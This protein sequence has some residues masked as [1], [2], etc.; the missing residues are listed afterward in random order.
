MR[1]SGELSTPLAGIDD[2]MASLLHLSGAAFFAWRA[3]HLSRRAGP[4][5]RRAAALYVFSATAVAALL[6][7]GT[8]HAIPADHAW[9]PLLQRVDHSAIFLLIAGTLTA[10]HAIGFHGRGRWWMVGLVWA[11]T[12]AVLFGKIAW[13]SRVGDG[14]G[15]GL[16]IGLSIVGLSSILFL[17]RKLDWRMYDL[18]AAGAV[19]YVAGALFD[20]F[21]LFWIVPRVFG[22]HETFH[23]AVLVALFLHWRFFHAWAEPGLAPRPRRAK[24]ELLRQSPGPN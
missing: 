4:A 15:L 11:I 6:L 14:V 19:T 13:W 16:Y 23:V 5:R 12:W 8:Y 3:T 18:M 2:P 21:Q 7:S 1:F 17:P 22:P 10:F 24:R 9:K 20:H